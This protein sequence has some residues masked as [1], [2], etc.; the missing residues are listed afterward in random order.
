MEDTIRKFSANKIIP[1][2]AKLAITD[3]TNSNDQGKKKIFSNLFIIIN[4]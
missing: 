3:A 1:S 2:Y 4:D